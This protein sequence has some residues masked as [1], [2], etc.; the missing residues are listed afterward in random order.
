MIKLL[1]FDCDG[2]IVDTK[3][4]HFNSFNSA[5]S[6]WASTTSFKDF[7]I[8]AQ[9]AS[10]YNGLPTK[11]K[12]QMLTHN[13]RLPVE[14]YPTIERLKQ[15]YTIKLIK[16]QIKESD[17]INIHE[18]LQ[19][20][21]VKGYK[22]YCA[23]NCSPDTLNLMLE[24]AGHKQY[25]HKIFS[26]ADVI[27]PKPSPEMFL[28][29]AYRAGLHPYDVLVIEDSDKG[30]QAARA[31]NMNFLEVSSPKDVTLDNI[32]SFITKCNDYFDQYLGK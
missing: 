13:K 10:I 21:S 16:E 20:L 3:N 7:T 18:V 9:E 30:I 32:Q 28:K 29:C 5:L 19:W 14:S 4:L 1:I 8:T 23:S 12:L 15:E 22:L 27:E 2:T 26:N 31:A 24:L 11:I 25:F 17:Y 6:E